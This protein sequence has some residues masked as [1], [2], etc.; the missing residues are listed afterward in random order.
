MS[1]SLAKGGGGTLHDIM[2]HDSAGESGSELDAPAAGAGAAGASP[3]SSSGF[4]ELIDEPPVQQQATSPA[5]AGPRI[6]R[7]LPARRAAPAGSNLVGSSSTEDDSSS[8]SPDGGVISSS[9]D[10]DHDEDQEQEDAGSPAAPPSSWQ[11]VDSALQASSPEALLVRAVLIRAAYGGT[12]GDV[13]MMLRAAV[14]LAGHQH[15]HHLLLPCAARHCWTHWVPHP[16]DATTTGQAVSSPWLTFLREVYQ[17]LQQPGP[18]AL[19]TT[20]SVTMVAALAR[21]D[22][23]LASVDFHVA[24]ALTQHL[25]QQPSLQ[26]ALRALATASPVIAA[27][28]AASGPEQLVNRTLWLFRSSINHKS[29]LQHLY[30]ADAE[31]SKLQQLAAGSPAGQAAAAFVNADLSALE[32]ALGAV[33]AERQLL[34]PLWKVMASL[35]DAWSRDLLNKRLY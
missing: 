28:L 23:P 3:A 15:N 34:L 22:I 27:R 25:L 29:W 30:S 13:A 10:E 35:A 14:N 12:E 2:P 8:S 1:A 32:A 33:K 9:D 11:E 17:Q 18:T 19:A 16:L 7:L 26:A 21:E 4:C 24:P 31:Q 6:T 20:T 5:A